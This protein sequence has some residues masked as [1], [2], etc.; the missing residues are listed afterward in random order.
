[1]KQTLKK[2]GYLHH[3]IR[4]GVRKDE[5]I[6]KKTLNKNLNQQPNPP[7]KKNIFFTFA[8]CGIE[9]TILQRIK[10]I[11]Q[12]YLPHTNIDVSF[13]KTF[14]LK[15]IFLPIQ[16]GDD[17]ME[18]D[19]KLVYKIACNECKK[20]Y[21]GETSREKSTGMKEHQKDIRS[22]SNSS[23]TVKHVTQHK[24]AFNFQQAK[25]LTYESN[26]TRRIIKESLLTHEAL[27]QALNYV[28][29]QLNIFGYSSELDGNFVGNISSTN[30][31][32]EL[33]MDSSLCSLISYRP[34]K[35]KTFFH[36]FE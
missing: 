30:I 18:K 15:N 14:T 22:V 10:Y 13:K 20:F 31:I 21:I 7:I 11:C 25:T 32:R 17:K 12:K 33:S 35:Y 36:F 16:K 24:H 19:K 1:M 2:N 5:V 27:G 9:S 3:S 23:N 29:F 34:Y 8:Y 28:K 6:A 26:W 4:R